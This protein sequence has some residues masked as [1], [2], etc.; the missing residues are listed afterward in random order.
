MNSLRSRYI[1]AHH[2]LQVNGFRLNLSLTDR[3]RSEG[4]RLQ[5]MF[6][7]LDLKEAGAAVNAYVIS[8]DATIVA[9]A[10]SES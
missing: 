3:W 2:L 6:N 5:P 10:R 7:H 9:S 1:S 4:H 8:I